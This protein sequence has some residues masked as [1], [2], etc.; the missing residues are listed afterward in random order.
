[1]AQHTTLPLV[2]EHAPDGGAV[3][4]FTLSPEQ[5]TALAD[6]GMQ[7]RWRVADLHGLCRRLA[8]PLADAIGEATR[9]H[10]GRAVMAEG[11]AS[12]PRTAPSHD[13]EHLARVNHRTPVTFDYKGGKL[14]GIYQDGERIG[15]PA[16]ADTPGDT[17]A[18][19]PTG[20]GRRA[21][22]WFRGAA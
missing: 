22:N 1:M 18:A 11:I 4:R 7:R 12:M 2:I 20:P 10:R 16:E 3:L 14:A 21:L 17:K 19:R 6:N 15:G 5:A 8:Q 9:R 13:A